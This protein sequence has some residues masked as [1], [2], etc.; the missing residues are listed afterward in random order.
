MFKQDQEYIY[1]FRVD[2]QYVYYEAP[3]AIVALAMAY[4]DYPNPVIDSVCAEDVDIDDFVVY[5]AKRMT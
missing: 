2:G 1:R 4:A 3:D 5:F